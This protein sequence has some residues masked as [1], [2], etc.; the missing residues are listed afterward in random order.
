MAKHIDNWVSFDG[1]DEAH[2][3]ALKNLKPKSVIAPHEW[4]SLRE[5]KEGDF[6]AIN[7][8]QR[9][10]A[11]FAASDP[12]RYHDGERHAKLIESA[13]SRVNT[14]F[15]LILYRGFNAPVLS[16]EILSG[17]TETFID[18]GFFS[19]SLSKRTAWNFAK[20]D[21][22]GPVHATIKVLRLT[23]ALYLE[24]AM[25]DH[26]LYSR[27]AE[28]LLQRGILYVVRDPIQGAEALD[29]TLEAM[30]L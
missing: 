23:P 3:W 8:S 12:G 19:T 26:K 20:K 14:P 7:A 28:V 4:A 13:I 1:V 24:F 5:Y 11:G 16:A 21:Q 22:P 17:A 27:E 15:N 2:A 29:V 9:D 18:D 6:G 10:P 25:P 30:V